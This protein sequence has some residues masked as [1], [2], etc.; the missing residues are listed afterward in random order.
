MAHAPQRCPVA[1]RTG[2]PEPGTEAMRSLLHL[3]NAGGVMWLRTTT[4][5]S[6]YRAGCVVRLP[7]VRTVKRRRVE[8]E[9]VSITGMGWRLAG[10]HWHAARVLS[11][12]PPLPDVDPPEN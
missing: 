12:P 5:W 3:A 4:A 9:L 11:E 7:N 1:D 10:D 2:P 6:L 8:H